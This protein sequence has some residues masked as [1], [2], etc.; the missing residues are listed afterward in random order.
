M[1]WVFLVFMCYVAF[2]VGIHRM[3]TFPKNLATLGL[4]FCFYSLLGRWNFTYI[5]TCLGYGVTF[6]LGA[7]FQADG[8]DPGGG[9]TN[10]LWKIWFLSHLGFIFLGLFIDFY[11]RKHI[12]SR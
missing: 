6:I 9:R 1:V 4:I 2:D 3:G 8:V 11:R 10:S 12:E 7:I 5:F